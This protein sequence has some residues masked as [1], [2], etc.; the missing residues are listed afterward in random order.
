MSGRSPDTWLA[1]ITASLIAAVLMW[2]AFYVLFGL[3]G[4]V[5]AL[6]AFIAVRR[7]R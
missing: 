2:P 7:K 1:V 3:L 6:W 4:I 5:A